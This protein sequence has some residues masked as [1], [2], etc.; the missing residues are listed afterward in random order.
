M[1]L[2]STSSRVA[3]HGTSFVKY[4]ASV[5]VVFK[6]MPQCSRN[7][8]TKY[9]TVELLSYLKND[10]LFYNSSS[11]LWRGMIDY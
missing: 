6:L 1:L 2:D 3:N 4:E 11:I 7:K 10:Y 8:I 9:D 5:C